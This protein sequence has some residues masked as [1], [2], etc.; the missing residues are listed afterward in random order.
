MIQE[1]IGRKVGKWVSEGKKANKSALMRRLLL[2]S[3]KVSPDRDLL[4]L[5]NSF[6]RVVLSE[7]LETG[8]FVFQ[9]SSIMGLILF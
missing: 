2:L 7:V 4:G 1:N 6:L 9:L 5:Y 3:T 8:T